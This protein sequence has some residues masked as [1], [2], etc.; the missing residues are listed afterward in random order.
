MPEL[1]STWIL[2]RLIG[3]AKASELLLSGRIFLGEEAAQLGVVNEAVDR[4]E[5]LPRAMEI[6]RGIAVHSAPAS[7]AL[8]KRIIWQNLGEPD[9]AQAA[10]REASAFAWLGQQADAKEGVVAFLEKRD[11]RWKLAPSS[12]PDAED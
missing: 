4:E 10:K 8:T 11:P 6:A 12:A 5:V 9:P 3:V 1:S 2:P 7:V